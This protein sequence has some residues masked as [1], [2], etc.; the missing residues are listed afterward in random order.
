MLAEGT[1]KAE[2]SRRLN[3]GRTSVHRILAVQAKLK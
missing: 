2:I 1:R 3:I